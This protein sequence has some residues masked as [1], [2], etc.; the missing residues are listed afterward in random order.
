MSFYC[1]LLPYLWRYFIWDTHALEIAG[2]EGGLHEDEQ[3][4]AWAVLRI[5]CVWNRHAVSARDLKIGLWALAVAGAL[6]LGFL[7]P[8]YR[9]FSANREKERKEPEEYKLFKKN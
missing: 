1:L 5:R 4:P 6:L 8:V 9:E 2:A 7:D 3:N